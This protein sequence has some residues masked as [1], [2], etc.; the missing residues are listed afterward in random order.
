MWHW[1]QKATQKAK[2]EVQVERVPISAKSAPSILYLETRNSGYTFQLTYGY[3]QRN[4]LNKREEVIAVPNILFERRAG[5]EFS[6]GNFRS[7][8]GH[9]QAPK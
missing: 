3:C 2:Y 9:Q 5:S 8:F 6:T 7:W 4:S 1:K